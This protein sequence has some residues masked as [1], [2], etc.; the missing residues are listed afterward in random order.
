MDTRVGLRAVQM[1]VMN[2]YSDR[3]LSHCCIM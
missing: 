1:Q 3:Q 2:I